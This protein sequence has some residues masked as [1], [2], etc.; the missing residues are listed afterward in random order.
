ILGYSDTSALLLALTLKTGIAT[1]H[2]PNLVDLQGE[3]LDQT[4]V[5][6]EEVLSPKGEMDISQYSSSMYHKEWQYD[7]PIEHV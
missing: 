2:G 4:T 6:W 5:M 1:A 7:N 3:E